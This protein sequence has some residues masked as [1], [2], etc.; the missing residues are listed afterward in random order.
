MQIKK[1]FLRLVRRIAAIM[2][3]FKMDFNPLGWQQT[4]TQTLGRGD[5]GA[6]HTLLR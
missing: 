4:Q 1:L 3:L 5:W 2:L 6:F